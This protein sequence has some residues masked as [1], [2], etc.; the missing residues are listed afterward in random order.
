MA[1]N[2]SLLRLVTPPDTSFDLHLPAGTAAVFEQRIAAHSRSQAQRVALP[3]RYTRGY[4][5]FRGARV[6]RDRRGAGRCQST[7]F[8]PT[9]SREWRRWSCRSRHRAPPAARTRLYTVRRGDTLVTIA[10]RFGVSLNQLRRWN[11]ITGIKVEP[12][13]RLHVADPA[14]APRAESRRHRAGGS[15]STAHERTTAPAK[16]AGAKSATPA[17]RRKG[18]AP[19]VKH[20]S[21]KHSGV[22]AATKGSGT[23]GARKPSMKKPAVHSK[24]HASK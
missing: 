20:G 24:S 4:A 14:S 6:S 9:A 3:P 19:T 18:A 12:G 10:D 17:A 7:W 21:A 22:E 2:P 16:D 23:H 5:G 8:Q 11:N 1:L 15:K 13:R